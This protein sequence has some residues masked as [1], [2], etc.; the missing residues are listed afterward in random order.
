MRTDYLDA[1]AARLVHCATAIV[2][3]P[4]SSVVRFN[5]TS[6]Q[7]GKMFDGAILRRSTDDWVLK[8]LFLLLLHS[9]EQKQISNSRFFL[10]KLESSKV[11]EFPLV[12]V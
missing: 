10:L 1:G 3:F 6:K 9:A 2:F 4:L 5:F 12:T 8:Y 11:V 7:D